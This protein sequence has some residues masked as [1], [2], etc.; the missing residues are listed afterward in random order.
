LGRAS[1]HEEGFTIIELLVVILMTGVLLTVSGLSIFGVFDASSR[2]AQIYVQEGTSLSVEKF[3]DAH[4]GPTT[5]SRLGLPTDS[6]GIDAT[7]ISGDQLV[8]TSRGSCYALSYDQARGSV[9]M[10][11]GKTCADVAT[12]ASLGPNKQS[13]TW[14]PPTNTVTLA[15]GIMNDASSEPVFTYLDATGA[16]I[17]WGTKSSSWGGPE[18]EATSASEDPWYSANV[19]GTSTPNNVASDPI[20]AV[21]VSLHVQS[22]GDSVKPYHYQQTAFL[23][24]SNTYSAPSAPSATAIVPQL[25]NCLRFTSCPQGPDNLITALQPQHTDTITASTGQWSGNP[26]PTYAYQWQRCDAQ[27]EDC[28]SL[29]YSDVVREDEPVEWWPLGEASGASWASLGTDEASLTGAG[30]TGGQPG[31]PTDTGGGAISVSPATTGSYPT[32]SSNATITGTFSVEA[33]VKPEALAGHCYGGFYSGCEEVLSSRDGGSYSATPAGT[34]DDESY[35]LAIGPD[36]LHSELGPGRSGYDSCPQ[37]WANSEADAP[38]TFTDGQWYHVVEAVTDSGAVH[39]YSFYVNGQL[40]TGGL[41]GADGQGSTD[42]SCT[43]TASQPLVLEDAS[44]HPTVGAYQPSGSPSEGFSGQISNV[45]LYDYALSGLQVANHYQ[46]GEGQSYNLGPT[47]I[48]AT[49]RVLVT[50]SNAYGQAEQGSA[51]SPVVAAIPPTDLTPP[52]FSALVGYPVPT[53]ESIPANASEVSLLAPTTTSLIAGPYGKLWFAEGGSYYDNDLNQQANV[54]QLGSVSTTGAFRDFPTDSNPPFASTSPCSTPPEHLAE[55]TEDDIWYTTNEGCVVKMDPTDGQVLAYDYLGG[56]LTGIAVTPDGKVWVPVASSTNA[57]D[58]LE[59]SGALEHSYPLP[60]GDSG[61]QGI[62]AGTDG[63]L[64][65]VAQKA[66]GLVILRLSSGLWVGT[67]ATGSSPYCGGSCDNSI[68]ADDSGD[69]WFTEGSSGQIGELST[70]SGAITQYP[71]APISTSST[72]TLALGQDGS[73]WFSGSCYQVTS[74]SS[75]ASCAQEGSSGSEVGALGRISPQ[76]VVSSYPVTPLDGKTVGEASTDVGSVAVGSDGNIYFLGKVYQKGYSGGFDGDFIGKLV[77]SLSSFTG[78]LEVGQSL[79][80]KEDGTWC[81]DYNLCLGDPQGLG[82]TSGEPTYTYQWQDCNSEGN[83]CNAIAEAAGP[84]YQ[85]QTSDVGHTLRVSITAHNS[86][87]GSVAVTSDA[88]PVISGIQPPMA[89]EPLPQIFGSTDVGHTLTA[90]KGTWIGPDPVTSYAYQWQDCDTNGEGCTDIAGASSSSYTLADSDV[91]HTLRVRVT[92]SNAGGAASESS[93]PSQQ[94]IVHAP[95]LQTAAAPYSSHTVPSPYASPQ[96]I[97]DGPDGSMW[98]SDGGGYEEGIH[99]RFSDSDS[100]VSNGII[101]RLMP[102]SSPAFTEFPDTQWQGT[103]GEPPCSSSA[104]SSLTAIF[105]RS[106]GGCGLPSLALLSG[107]TGELEPSQSGTGGFGSLGMAEEPG[108][109][110]GPGQTLWAPESPRYPNGPYYVDELSTEG[111]LLASYTLPADATDP[112]DISYGSDGDFWVLAQGPHGKDVVL[113][114]GTDGSWLGEYYTDVNTNPLS[115]QYPSSIVEGPDGDIWWTNGGLGLLSSVSPSTGA[116]TSYNVGGGAMSLISGQDGA[117]WFVYGGGGSAL[118]RLTTDGILTKYPVAAT[119]SAPHSLAEGSDGG[120]YFTQDFSRT[121][122]PYYPYGAIGEISLDL[123]AISGAPQAGSTLEASTGTWADSP[124][125]GYSYQWEDCYEWQGQECF[126][127]PGATSASYAVQASDEGSTLRVEVTA[128]NAGGSTTAT[129]APTAQVGQGAPTPAGAPEASALTGTLHTTSG[130]WASGTPTSYSYQWERCNASGGECSDIA[131]D[132]LLY[133]NGGYPDSLGFYHQDIHINQGA[134]LYDYTEQPAD[135]GQTLR[136]AVTAYDSAGHATQRSAPTAPI[137]EVPSVPG[138]SEP[139]IS[140]QTVHGDTLT[141][142][143]GSWEGGPQA[144]YSYQWLDCS[145]YYPLSCTDVAGATSPSYTL[146][147]SDVGS[148]MRAIVTAT[149]PDNKVSEMSSVTGLVLASAPVAEEPYPQIYGAEEYA[150]LSVDGHILLTTHGTWGGDPPGLGGVSPYTYQWEDCDA[151]G[152]SCTDIES[153]QSSSTDSYQIENGD[154]DHTI[155]VVVTAHN[156]AGSASETSAPIS[157]VAPHAP[158]VEVTGIDRYVL[159]TQALGQSVVSAPDG[160]LWFPEANGEIG[161]MTLSGRAFTQF[162]ASGVYTTPGSAVP[163]TATSCAPSYMAVGPEEDLWYTDNCSGTSYVV[164]MDSRGGRV[165]SAAAV[166]GYG[167]LTGIAEGPEG[168]MWALGHDPGDLLEL[169]SSGAVEQAYPLPG[170]DTVPNSLHYDASDDSLWTVGISE[171]GPEGNTYVEPYQFSLTTDA[172]TGYPSTTVTFNDGIF[173]NSI[174]QGPEGG[175]WYTKSTDRALS[176]LT[177]STGHSTD[178]QSLASVDGGNPGGLLSGLDGS[179]WSTGGGGISRLAPD[180]V[181][182]ELTIQPSGGCV[183]TTPV[184][185]TDALDADLYFTGRYSDGCESFVDQIG[186]VS[187]ASPAIS[188]GAQQGDALS[189]STGGWCPRA[190][191]PYQQPSDSSAPY[192][193]QGDAPGQDLPEGTDPYAYQWEDCDA[194]GQRCQSIPGATGTSYALAGTDVGHRL[195]VVVTATNSG[196]STTATSGATALI[197][198]EAPRASSPPPSIS[199]VTKSEP[200]DDL[201]TTPTAITQHGD[202]MVATD[203]TWASGALDAPTT[204]SYQWEDC[205]AQGEDCTSIPGAIHYSYAATLAD[206]GGTLRITVVASNPAGSASETSDPTTVVRALPPTVDAQAFFSELSIPTAGAQP[207]DITTGSDKR[208]WFTESGAD[209]IGV[210]TV[211]GAFSEYPAGS[212]GCDPTYIAS[213]AND[214]I[215]YVTDYCQ[216]SYVVSMSTSG[217]QLSSLPVSAALAGITSTPGGQAW[218]TAEAPSGPELLVLSPSGALEEAVSIPTSIASHPQGITYDAAGDMWFTALSPSGRDEAVSYSP[219]T[220]IFTPYEATGASGVTSS[221][222][223]NAIMVGADGDVYF[224]EDKYANAVAIVDVQTGEVTEHQVPAGE[225]GS[226]QGIATG[227]DGEVWLTADFAGALERMAQSGSLTSYSPLTSSNI[228]GLTLGPNDSLYFTEGQADKIGEATLSAPQLSGLAAVG[229]LLT[230]TTGTWGGDPAGAGLP[231]GTPPYTYQWEDCGAEGATSTCAPIAGATEARYTLQASDSGHTIRVQVTATNS[232]GSAS[233]YSPPSQVVA[234]SNPPVASTPGPAIT[235]GSQ[236]LQQDSVLSAT[237]GTWTGGAVSSYTYQWQRCSPSGSACVYITGATNASYTTTSADIGDTITVIVT[238]SNTY[239]SASE[240]SE[241]TGVVGSP[242]PPLPTSTLPAISGTAQHDSLLTTSNGTWD[243]GPVTAYSYQWQDCGK[244]GEGCTSVAGATLRT[245]TPQASDIGHTMRVVVTASNAAGCQEEGKGLCEGETSPAT[246]VVLAL[247][248]TVEGKVVY[249]VHAVPT[250]GAAPIGMVRGSDGDLWFLEADGGVDQVGRMTTS[251]VITEFP[252]APQ[253]VPAGQCTP[254]AD[255]QGPDGDLWYLTSCDG[256]WGAYIVQ[257]D[258]RGTVVASYPLEATVEGQGQRFYPRGDGVQDLTVG[259]DGNLWALVSGPGGSGWLLKISPTTG[260]VLGAYPLAPGSGISIEGLASGPN[261]DLWAGA[262]QNGDYAALEVD[263]SGNVVEDYV[264]Q[265]GAGCCGLNLAVGD[266]GTSLYLAEGGT[267]SVGDL[268][269]Q[270]GTITQIQVPG[271]LGGGW[272]PDIVAGPEGDVWLTEEGSGALGRISASGEAQSFA[273]PATVAPASLAVGPD[274]NIYFADGSGSVGEA[275]VSLP[276]ISGSAEDG[277]TLSVSEGAWGGDPPG[278]GL[279]KASPA[280]TYQWE[281][282]GASGAGCTDISGATSPSYVVGSSD[283]GHALRAVVWAYNSG[284]ASTPPATTAPTVAGLPEAPKPATPVPAITGTAQDGNT[285]TTSDGTWGGDPVT[286]YAYQWCRS[287]GTGLSICPNGYSQVVGATSQS[288]TAQSADIGKSLAVVVT[289]SN[290]GGSAQEDSSPTATVIPAVPPSPSTPAPVISGISQHGSTLTT[291]N[292]TWGGGPVASYAYQWE[293]CEAHGEGCSDIEGATSSVYVPALEDIGHTLLVVITATNSGGSGTESSA[294]TP[295]VSAIPPQ[296]SSPAPYVSGEAR[297]GQTLAATNGS[298]T[299]DELTYSYQWQSCSGST[300]TDISG[301]TS[302]TYAIAQPDIGSSLRIV[303]TASNSAGTATADSATT[304]IVVAVAPGQSTPGPLITDSTS[305]G[306]WR[307]GD[308]LASTNGT[309]TGDAVISYAYQWE[310]CD[311]SGEGCSDISGAHSSSYALAPADIGHTLRLTVTAQ[312]SGGQASETSAP[313]GTVLAIPPSQSSPA[314]VISGTAQDGATL[315]TTNGTWGGDAASYTYQWQDCDASGEGCTGIE[316]ATSQGYTLVPGDEGHTVRVLVSASNSGGQAGPETSAPTAQVTVAQPAPTTPYPAISGEARDGQTLSTTNG[317]W[318]GDAIASYTYQWQDC[319]AEGYGCSDIAGA[320]S[321]SYALTPGD[322]GHAIRAQVTAQ[323]AGGSGQEASAPTSAVLAIPPTAS[324]PGPV[325]SGTPQTGATL[326]TT[327]GTFTGDAASYSYQWQDCDTSGEGCADISGATSSSYYLQ[328]SD[329]GHTMVVLVTATNN[330]GHATE[331]SQP[332]ATVAAAPPVAS[333]PGPVVSGTTEH[334]QTLTVSNG[335]WTGDAPTS[336]SYQW[337]HC[338]P[339]YGCPAVEGA[340]SQSY[341]LPASDVGDYIYAIVTASDAAGPTQAYSNEVGP[342]TAIPPTA[343][344]P[345]PAISG[346]AADEQVLTTTNGAFGGDP[347]TSYTYQW[348]DCEASGEGCTPISGATSSAYTLA[349]SDVGSTIIVVVTDHNSGGSASE[350]SA[351]TPVV[352]AIPPQASSPAP[353]ISGAPQKGSTLSTT[354]GTFTGGPTSYAYQWSDCDSQGEACT[355]IAGATSSTY[356]L[357]ASD[358]GS[359]IAVIVTA[360]N[361]AGQA[362]ETSAPTQAVFSPSPY[363]RA[364]AANSPVEWWRLTEPSDTTWANYGTDTAPMQGSGLEGGQQSIPGDQPVGG[365]VGF[366]KPFSGTYPYANTT[367][368]ISG[369]FSVDLWVKLSTVPGPCASSSCAELVNTRQDTAAGTSFDLQLGSEGLHSDIGNGYYG[370]GC[371]GWLNTGVNAPYSFSADQWYDI[372]ETVTYSS[373]ALYVDGQ[374]VGTG[375]TQTCG[376]PEEPV[377][378]D[379]DHHPDLGAFT[380]RLTEGYSQQLTGADM[381]EVAFYGKALT[382]AQVQSDYEAGS[383]GSSDLGS[384][385]PPS[386]SDTTSTGSFL[387]GDTVS[388]TDG[389]WAGGPPTSY[390]YQ[391]LRCGADSCQDIPGATGQSYTLGSTDLGSQVEAVVTASDTS[392]YAQADSAQSPTVTSPPQVTSAPAVTGNAVVGSPLT[393]SAGAWEGTPPISYSYQWRRGTSTACSASSEAIEGASGQSYTAISADSGAKLCVTVTASNGVGAN[394]ATSPSTLPVVEP[395][396]YYTA[397]AGNSPVEWWRLTEGSNTTWAN[398]GTDTAPMQAS[399][400]LGGQ[401]GIPGDFPGGGSVGF[402][403]SF[404]GTDPYANTTATISGSFTVD[405]WV[406][407]SSLPPACSQGCPDVVNTRQTSA[408]GGS[409]GN[410]FDL[411]IGSEELHSDIGAGYYGNGCS[412]W[413]NTAANASY[414]GLAPYQWYD[415]TEVVTEEAYTFYVD[416]QEVGSG[417]TQACGSPAAPLLTDAYHHPNLGAWTERLTEGYSQQLTNADVSEVAFYGTALTPAQVQGDYEVGNEGPPQD[418]APPALR[419]ATSPGSYAVGDTLTASTGTWAGTPTSYSYQ[420]RRGT[421]TSCSESSEA[422]EGATSQEYTTVDADAGHVL[423]VAV[424]ASNSFGTSS[425]P[426]LSR[427]DDHVDSTGT[428]PSAYA[429]GAVSNAQPGPFANAYSAGFTGD[430]AIT[431][432]STPVSS[433]EDWTLEAWIYPTSANQDGNIIYDG[434]QGGGSS[435]FGLLMTANGGGDGTGSCLSGLYEAVAWVQSG[436]CSFS[437]DKWY[438]VALVNSGGQLTF[439]VYEPS[440]HTEWSGCQSACSQTPK[441][442]VGMMI[443]GYTAGTGR[444]FYGDISNAAYYGQ[445]LSPAQIAAHTAAASDEETYSAAVMADDPAAYF[446]LNDHAPI[447]TLSAPVD[448]TPPAITGKAQ[449]GQVLT[450][451][452]GSWSGVPAPTYTYQWQDCDE[453]GEGCTDIEGATS[454][455]YTVA[456]SDE[457]HT[458]EVLVTATNSQGSAQASS[459]PTGV[460]T[461]PPPSSW[462]APEAMAPGHD[463]VAVSCSPSTL[464]M[465]VDSEATAYLSTD[466][467]STSPAWAPSGEPHSSHLAVACPSDSLCISTTTGGYTDIAAVSGTG[468]SWSSSGEDSTDFAGVACGSASFCVYIDGSAEYVDYASSPASARSWGPRLSIGFRGNAIA[469][470][471]GTSAGSGLCLVVGE[472]G[473]IASST[474]PASSW[475]SGSIPGEASSLTSVSCTSDS[476]CVAVDNDGNAFYSTDPTSPSSWAQTDI[477]GTHD[478][479]AVSCETTSDRCAAVDASGNAL[480]SLDGGAT[481]GAPQDIDPGQ[482][483]TGASCAPGF[484]LAVD[485]SGNVLVYTG[486]AA[487]RAT[488][489]PTIS[490]TPAPGQVLTASPGP[491]SGTV[492]ITYAYQWSD[493]EASGE[494][495]TDIEGATSATY[496]L[497]ASDVGHT[498]EVLVT[499]TNAVGSGEASSAPTPEVAYPPSNTAAPAIS[500]S[501]TGGQALTASTG[502]WSGSPSS[503]AYQWSDCEA[504]GEGCTDIAGA[505]SSSYTLTGSDVGDTIAVVVT[506]R[507]ASGEASKASTTPSPVVAGV[508]PSSSAVPTISGSALVGEA[509]TASP[510]AWT[511]YPSATYAYQWEDCDASGEGCTDIEGATEATYTL[512]DSDE[513]D[514]VEVVVTATNSQGSGHASSQPTAQVAGSAAWGAPQQLSGASLSAASCP[515]GTSTCVAV[516]SSTGSYSTTDGGASWQAQPSRPDGGALALSCPTSAFCLATTSG[517]YSEPASVSSGAISWTGDNPFGGSDFDAVSCASASLCAHVD[518]ASAVDYSTTPSTRSGG[519]T[520][521]SVTGGLTSL[522]CAP[523][524]T[525]TS[526]LCLAGDTN[527]HIYASTDLAA[528]SW[529]AMAVDANAITSVSCLSTSLC[530]AVDSAGNALRSTEP[531]TGASAWTTQD[532]DGTYGLD[533]VSCAEGLCMAVDGVGQAL[534]ST[535]GGL[536]WGVPQDIDGSEGLT[537][538]SC[539]SPALCVATDSSGHVVAYGAQAA[540]VSQAAPGISGEAQPGEVLTASTGSWAGT[541]APTYTY[542]WQD[543]DEAG[544]GCTDIEGATSQE[545][546]VAASDEGHTVEVLVTATNSQ[547][548]AQASSEPTSVVG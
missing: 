515:A 181:A 472:Q 75:G 420:W 521:E 388:T 330:A 214:D 267:G 215:W 399:G 205:D 33:W 136:V 258:T 453:A 5:S 83:E 31:I 307:D 9:Y 73:I 12:E 485:A 426:A 408:G 227:P 65:L 489:A 37:G 355:D 405:L 243:G 393:A 61:P 416:G 160:N 278:T 419:D 249:S 166:T 329:E 468:A 6:G 242:T 484:C 93:A 474:T 144:S 151:S 533:A 326:S 281:S 76:G 208:L 407:F 174:A 117:L 170:F 321:Q 67:T 230:V 495:C 286:S 32:A 167:T 175:L 277:E 476:S 450:A 306:A 232:G 84:S 493:C 288:Y 496:S 169:S 445:A 3:I 139:L 105:Y 344:T 172:W 280:Y 201:S 482:A 283:I 110:L 189:A 534:S 337:Y 448:S 536:E 26:T 497:Q 97:T 36:G 23:K 200:T 411:A 529:S 275:N 528:R 433:T 332:T 255:V 368:T 539:A 70:V 537:S 389:S 207:F 341:T 235:V 348:S 380:E 66:E 263:T 541:P 460:V 182:D 404:S 392:G 293:R 378:I 129:S 366:P 287:G 184:G 58:E 119:T 509:L 259:P 508:I 264:T 351:P 204:Y 500:G 21:Q 269:T 499:A 103:P 346:T 41:V 180:G 353:V 362:T 195:R 233:T 199:D 149:S 222:E 494:G 197:G 142:T 102:G 85:I 383:Q 178:F 55:G 158:M 266:D 294:P 487:P 69:M 164:R 498:V 29:H 186:E 432:D 501:Y 171:P 74:G 481:W 247:R 192:V 246:S 430:G 387:V 251:G 340:T 371:S 216:H 531:A 295:V 491:W 183:G 542:Q 185:L 231:S 273:A 377:L 120:L 123:P 212:S 517:G 331:A 40:V 457:G 486:D 451:S 428:L 423:C 439:Y 342:V 8:F 47:D 220:R 360:T 305:P 20:A 370:N 410:S 15:D 62:A 250:S 10:T 535:D 297:D 502:T 226:Q 315:V 523:G 376:V 7:S 190:L 510:G 413:D 319:N 17:P 114:L 308:A 452:V 365:S 96:S 350:P 59:P 161:R 254:E 285:L 429:L 240:T 16:P 72:P 471:P 437:A 456:A 115:S 363:S 92:A 152:G 179:L 51:T 309:F 163:P 28:A 52:G 538:V 77:L 395:S 511:A 466:A 475:S 202:T 530:V 324:T 133:T 313:T 236:L 394:S 479:K 505:T 442:P 441:P 125:T 374:E 148:V 478:I 454:Q 318:G 177:P 126:A 223:S 514:T 128:S 131:T 401:Q 289:A 206:V 95:V 545:Y 42:A 25:Y 282:C 244:G 137:T 367:A 547:G 196:G 35:D 345:V 436:Y 211:A 507:S 359:T 438:Y 145:Q 381:S 284:G 425:S 141:V 361:S 373:W 44:H 296:A 379:A 122:Y 18:K 13:G 156:N 522:S 203:G 483:L 60:T 463:L 527:G 30:V 403:S 11:E 335:T 49:M 57:V 239:G 386:V 238:A 303:V 154:I 512:A 298:F 302:P 449:V 417:P 467:S 349:P 291:T 328:P 4:L 187:L 43:A 268:D 194:Y 22:P 356:T 364:I 88:S 143:D 336:Y 193:C 464:C 424:T 260:T 532:I 548:S 191:N 176:T 402:P 506:A 447:T 422:I 225:G 440:T 245:Y 54:N 213:G 140:G 384:T 63:D 477:D 124:P 138:S 518:S 390:A 34:P 421:P 257:M 446:R 513:G 299:G 301:A 469:C 333:S 104:L 492:P 91:G 153:P 473:R 261:G 292:G 322:V 465:A 87:G 300:C 504:S 462:S 2:S 19:S 113:Q 209:Q 150:S 352:S 265:T 262:V 490:G 418:T 27:G 79:S 354:N 397:I 127:I 369:S 488:G 444:A 339:G 526:G 1:S 248:P 253:G 391:W 14:T 111:A 224:T 162:E 357:E 312:N 415:V 310:D 98:F 398:Y 24:V 168:R 435:G 228:G 39:R 109:A 90:S 525:A 234:E 270:T 304:S 112:Q 431:S 121:E 107:S 146:Q 56:S 237:E 80:L 101:T 50:A 218:V 159:P 147:A 100:T 130:T 461:T 372:T 135:L 271:V 317:T 406:E 173:E 311:T 347:A 543:C 252:A 99:D 210:L 396:S 400:V 78:D 519:W 409:S 375:P 38:Y 48:G 427:T 89:Y 455:E 276:T 82:L 320:T 81:Q 274:D 198:Q 382:P 94:V 256:T 217:Q 155:R 480:V 516:D 64:Y 68:I 385:A 221:S 241:P 540:P 165:L 53:P 458:V 314:P 470:A 323:N 443:G 459:A 188:G 108:G 327:N 45:A 503:Y 86:G 412:G 219:T 414:T 325:I 334:G 272:A 290:A 106:G 134:D 520:Q 157:V 524:T 118:G 343:G 338:V 358:V 132:T 546:T 544:E 71:T 316:G 229:Q 279:P 46:G 434:D 116:V